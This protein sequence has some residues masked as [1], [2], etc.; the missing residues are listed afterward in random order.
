MADLGLERGDGLL[1]GRETG[2]V[3]GAWREEA[4]QVRQ[5]RRHDLHDAVRGRGRALRHRLPE[6]LPR[7]AEGREIEV[8]LRQDQTGL[9]Q[10]HRVVARGGEF[11]LGRQPRLVERV[12][13]R[14]PD[15]RHAA[16][17][18]RVLQ[19]TCRAFPQERAPGHQNA[20]PRGDR[21]LAKGGASRHRAVVEG[22]HIGPECLVVQADR[23]QRPTEQPLDIQ[24]AERGSSG[25]QAVAEHDR[26]PVLRSKPKR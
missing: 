14:P 12:P 15:L 2:S 4:R 1:H 23:R 24:H 26:V 20:D 9:G 8:A 10:D 3:L 13:E 22:A 7:Q 17:A 21:L 5:S 11:D 6:P 16:I 18:Q 19:A 25:R